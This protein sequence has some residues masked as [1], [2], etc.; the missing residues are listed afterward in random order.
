LPDLRTSGG[1]NSGIRRSKNSCVTRGEHRS[2]KQEYESTEHSDEATHEPTHKPTLKS[3]NTAVPSIVDQQSARL[4][5]FLGIL[6]V[7]IAPHRSPLP[8]A[9]HP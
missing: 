2:G 6:D 5:G 7:H 4:L 1:A 9:A 3:V 8:F